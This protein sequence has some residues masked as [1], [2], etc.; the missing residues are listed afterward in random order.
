LFN[1]GVIMRNLTD[2]ESELINNTE[3]TVDYSDE[4]DTNDNLSGEQYDYEQELEHRFE[5]MVAEKW[6]ARNDLGG[7]SVFFKDDKLIAFYDYEQCV[8]TIFN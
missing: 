8:G 2:A 4:I 5:M 3:Y 6:D 1:K 7:I